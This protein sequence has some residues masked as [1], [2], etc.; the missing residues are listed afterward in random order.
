MASVICLESSSSTNPQLWQSPCIQTHL[1][2]STIS[3]A[4]ADDWHGIIMWSVGEII[5]CM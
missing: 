5:K 1:Y 4:A 2:P 3:E